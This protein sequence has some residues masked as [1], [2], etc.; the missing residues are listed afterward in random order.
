MPVHPWT[1]LA[2][3][4]FHFEGASYLLIVDFTSRFLV[5]CK[6]SS[7]AGVHFANQCK[8]VFSEYGWLRPWYQIMVH[9]I[10]LRHSS[11][12]WKCLVSIIL[13]ALHF[14]HSQ[15]DLQRSMCRLYSACF[16]KPMK[17][18]IYTGVWW[19]TTIPLTGSLQLP[20]Q[21]LQG[22]S[23]RS[24]LQMSKCCEETAWDPA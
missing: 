19:S 12:S 3:D 21:I 7:M 8:L 1:K 4:I 10:P 17:V 18:K 2:T 15:M 22:R 23:A 24:N 6:L 9:A 16:T 13:Q 5:V 14:T 20:M 11:V